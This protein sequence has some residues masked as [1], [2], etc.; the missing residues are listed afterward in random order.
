MA[1][2]RQG[3]IADR[4]ERSRFW[5]PVLERYPD[6]EDFVMRAPEEFGRLR[7][8]QVDYLR[9]RHD[10]VDLVGRT[11]SL[12]DDVRRVFAH[13]D[14]PLPAAVPRTNA[15][16]ATGYREHYTPAMR[17]RVAEIFAAD[18]DEFGYEF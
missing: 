12:D 1:R 13:L 10:R 14:L 9:T 18:L 4:V 6:F 17:D 2:T 8:A 7:R 11:E 5:G 15:G 3:R 16:P